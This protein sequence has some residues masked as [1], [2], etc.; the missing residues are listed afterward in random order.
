MASHPQ[1]AA[2]QVTQKEVAR[3]EARGLVDVHEGLLGVLV[4]QG[5]HGETGCAVGLPR[6]ELLQALERHP[7]AGGISVLEVE[8]ADAA[9]ARAVLRMQGERGAKPASRPIDLARSNCR[10]SS[11]IGPFDLVWIERDHS[12]PDSRRRVVELVLIELVREV[13]P[14]T[15]VAGTRFEPLQ[16]RRELGACHLIDS[17][18][19]SEV[20]Q[21]WR[22]RRCRSARAYRQ[23]QNKKHRRHAVASVP[24][25]PH[26]ALVI[27]PQATALAPVLALIVHLHRRG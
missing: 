9:P 3:R 7:R 5:H 19:G 6:R 11:A 16:G 22:R 20:R 23:Q 14:Q 26:P 8:L 27:A 12:F 17:V 4:E 25:H 10:D 1:R 18:Q 21:R 13:H 15:H 2:S 24:R